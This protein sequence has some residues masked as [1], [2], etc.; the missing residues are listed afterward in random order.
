MNYFIPKNWH[1]SLHLP[2]RVDTKKIFRFKVTFDLNCLY[3]LNSI[4]NLDINKLYGFSFGNNHHKNS[5]RI[6]W[7]CQEKND[8]ISLFAYWYQNGDRNSIKLLDVDI[9][10]EIQITMINLPSSNKCQIVIGKNIFS[11]PFN[12]KDIER[13]GWRLFPYFGGNQKTPHAMNIYL[14]DISDNRVRNCFSKLKLK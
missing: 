12:Y 3:D 9:F 8:K 5:I 11:I 4:D 14:E 10:Q 2:W 7:N 1:Y 13:K 6:G